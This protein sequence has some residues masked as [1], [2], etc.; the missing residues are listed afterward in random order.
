M[1]AQRIHNAIQFVSFK[2]VIKKRALNSVC[3]R[4]AR[5]KQQQQEENR[6]RETSEKRMK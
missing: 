6:K 5:E 2:V 4:K 3:G 1:C